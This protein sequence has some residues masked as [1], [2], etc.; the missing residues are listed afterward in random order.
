[1]V[2]FNDGDD[3]IPPDWWEEATLHTGVPPMTAT[4][5]VALA[6]AVQ[7]VEAQAQPGERVVSLET[8]APA[9][10]LAALAL[11]EAQ[12]VQWETELELGPRKPYNSRDLLRTLA[13][14]GAAQLLAEEAG[15]RRLIGIR[16]PAIVFDR[17]ISPSLTADEVRPEAEIGTLRASDAA[18]FDAILAGDDIAIGDNAYSADEAL[19]Y[20]RT[21]AREIALQLASWR[22]V[23]PVMTAPAVW[24]T[25]NRHGLRIAWYEC[26]DMPPLPTGTVGTE[27]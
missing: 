16:P 15:A 10:A 12:R 21:Y 4:A 7:R 23:D 22:T 27:T 9:V 20:L 17:S 8:P 18:A 19:D 24:G 25:V 11:S 2:D 26:L 5:L 3:D 13:P 1:M 14:H 6:G